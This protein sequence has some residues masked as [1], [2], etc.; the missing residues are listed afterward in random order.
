MR[1]LHNGVA[2]IEGMPIDNAKPGKAEPEKWNPYKLWVGD[3]WYCP[4]C[5]H[6][7]IVGCTQRPVAEH[8]QP[9]FQKLAEAYGASLLVKDC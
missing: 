2:F 9:D 4:D 5:S 7:I 8:Y 6:T 3:E 1:P